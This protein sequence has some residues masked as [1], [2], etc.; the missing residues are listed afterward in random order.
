MAIKTFNQKNKN[1]LADVESVAN[2]YQTGMTGIDA[3]LATT[4][5][6]SVTYETGTI[7]FMGDSNSRDEYNWTKDSMA[8]FS[9]ETPQQI[10]GTLNPA[11]VASDLPLFDLYSCCGGNVSV[12]GTTGV[13]TVTNNVAE[14]ST[15]SLNYVKTSADDAVN[16]KLFRFYGVRGTV[17]ASMD[18]SDVPRLKFALKGNALPI[19][20]AANITPNYGAQSTSI[21]TEIRQNS[22]VSAQIA[23]YYENFNA[24]SVITGTPTIARTGNIATVTLASHGLVTGQR[25]NISGATGAV[26]AF[27][28]NGDF[29]VTVLNSGTFTYSM[30]GTP[31]GAAAGTL[32]AKKDGYSKTFCFD[33]LSAP[34]FFGF[35]LTRY[36][37]SCIEGY[38]RKAVASDVTLTALETF[39]PTFNITSI[40]KSGTTATLTTDINHGLTATGTNSITVSGASDPLYNGTFVMATAATNTITYVMGG[41]PAANAVAL[42]T[43]SMVLTD[44]TSLNFDPDAHVSEYFT[45]KLKTG[46]TAG[47]YLTYLWD[48][49]QLKAVKDAQVATSE[50]REMTFRNTGKAFI[51]LE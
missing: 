11:L 1:V 46:R 8:D 35:D 20:T 7:E 47:R 23:P 27:Y 9:L 24:Q 19:V 33:K 44:N 18:V 21:A 12:N 28:Y 26:D 10:L 40:T 50:G 31:S 22:V 30:N 51:I 37:T 5:S 43:G 14:V 42:Y 41:T 25:V 34:N 48:K 45:V 49:L 15:A 4:I 32:V 6:G 17:D 16:G 29:Q 39:S 36:L 13:V 2:A 38:D 3:I